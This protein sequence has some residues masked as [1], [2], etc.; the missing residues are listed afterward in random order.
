MEPLASD[1]LPMPH[2]HALETPP[3]MHR[4]GAGKQGFIDKIAYQE[5]D[6]SGSEVHLTK[7]ART[8]ERFLGRKRLI[9][10]VAKKQAIEAMRGK[11][12]LSGYR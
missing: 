10:C 4:T 1:E 7:I 9:T 8:K 3:F 6:A 12:I 5:R 11:T 2:T